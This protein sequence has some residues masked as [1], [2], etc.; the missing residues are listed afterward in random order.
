MSTSEIAGR[1]AAGTSSHAGP[2]DAGEA[3]APDGG[4]NHLVRGSAWFVASVMI[5]A[6]GGFIV[7][8][9]ATGVADADT[10]GRAQSLQVAVLFVTYATGMG[11]PV[12]V[13]R[14]AGANTRSVN[15]LYTWALLYTCLSSIVGTI[16]FY[17][18]AS[19]FMPDGATRQAFEQLNQWGTIPGAAVFFCMVTGMSF[20][21]LV[22][23]RLV[24]LRQWR[25]VL[26][27]VVLLNAVRLPLLFVPVLGTTTLGLVLILVGVPAASGLIGAVLI[28][29]AT[30][31]AD[32]GTLFPVPSEARPALRYAN[33]HYVGMLSA[34]APQFTVPLLVTSSV[35]A[36]DASAFAVAWLITAVV[37]LIP[38]TVGQVLLAES[39]RQPSAVAPQVRTAL[40]IT[41][42]TMIVAAVGAIVLGPRLA[43]TVFGPEYAL[44]G[45][46]LGRFVSAGV[47]WAI[48]A[49]LLARAR[50][51]GRNRAA[52]I[53]TGVFA[54]VTLGSVAA[55][56][57]SGGVEAAATA[58][59]IANV[60]AALAAIITTVATRTVSV[61]HLVPSPEP[62]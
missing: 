43:T 20:T 52:I 50:V 39:S 27:R 8:W 12:A 58:W 7:T 59:L 47:P 56:V 38:H 22:E 17:V 32:R 10:L 53:I 41:V 19:V 25:W 9:I 1:P 30:P 40:L 45:E 33:V 16:G 34:Q 54:V 48:T 55:V 4:A 14:Y 31:R 51:L 35:P 5:G 61:G 13:A 6:L 3:S 29:L 36:A 11:L 26:A 46:V 24:T 49:T 62:T 21:L 57:G 60:V 15:V 2:A 44:P 28:R 23:V 37:F 18:V 42:P